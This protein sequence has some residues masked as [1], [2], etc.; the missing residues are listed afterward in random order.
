MDNFQ[1]SSVL[2]SLHDFNS[3]EHPIPQAVKS[4][5]GDL[6]QIS[7]GRSVIPYTTKEEAIPYLEDI[8]F[9]DLCFADND[10]DTDLNAPLAYNV[11]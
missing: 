1:L 10:F 9:D 2:I 8:I 3:P 6:R 5:V 4:L 11:L 7:A